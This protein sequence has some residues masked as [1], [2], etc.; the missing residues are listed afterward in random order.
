MCINCPLKKAQHNTEVLPFTFSHV[1]PPCPCFHSKTNDMDKLS[2]NTPTNSLY[3]KKNA[4]SVAWT[5]FGTLRI[6][7]FRATN[8]FN[9]ITEYK[10]CMAQKTSDT[11]KQSICKCHTMPKKFKKMRIKNCC[12]CVSYHKGHG[13]FTYSGTSC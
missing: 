6:N 10:E 5:H 9:H 7:C 13:S 12:H 2:E 4:M 3:L 1:P 8:L 11:T